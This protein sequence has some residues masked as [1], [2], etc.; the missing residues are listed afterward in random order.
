MIFKDIIKS[1]YYKRC[2]PRAANYEWNYLNFK[3]VGTSKISGH[4]IYLSPYE[5]TSTE[6]SDTTPFVLDLTKIK[7]SKTTGNRV[8]S[9]RIPMSK[10]Y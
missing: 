10:R 6:M 8:F 4:V 1:S 7:K 9:H 5:T 3:Q 2:I